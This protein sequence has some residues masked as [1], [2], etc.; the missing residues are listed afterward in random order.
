[1]EANHLGAVSLE[2]V[3]KGRICNVGCRI[4]PGISPSSSEKKRLFTGYVPVWLRIDAYAIVLLLLR[5][6]VSNIPV[7][8]IAI[9]ILVILQRYE[10]TGKSV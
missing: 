3:D 10:M 9:R 1:V 8:S 6:P 5:V 4:K 7:R 2:W